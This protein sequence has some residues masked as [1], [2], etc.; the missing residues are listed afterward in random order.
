MSASSKWAWSSLW[1]LPVSARISL[2]THSHTPGAGAR[3]VPNSIRSSN[4]VGGCGLSIEYCL[5][6][7]QF[8]PIANIAQYLLIKMLGKKTN[9]QVEIIA[10]SR[11]L[12]GPTKEI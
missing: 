2:L 3:R 8:Q 7:N 1:M 11:Y 5:L 6:K 12:I 10:M 4:E 9:Q